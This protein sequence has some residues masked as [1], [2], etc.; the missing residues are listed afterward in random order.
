M[1]QWTGQ[2]TC[3]CQTNGGPYE[4]HQPFPWEWNSANASQSQ[5]Q[6]RISQVSRDDNVPLDEGL[7]HWAETQ[8]DDQLGQNQHRQRNQESNLG[9]DIVQEREGDTTAE[10]VPAY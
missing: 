10:G 2:R 5:W 3:F 1:W 8:M 9:L 7:H 6:S 4:N